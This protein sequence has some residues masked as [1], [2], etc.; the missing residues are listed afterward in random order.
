ELQKVGYDGPWM[1]E[2]ANTSTPKAVL[3][4]VDKARKRFERLL[5]MSFENPQAF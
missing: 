3:E 5:D 1:F 2:V 4:Q